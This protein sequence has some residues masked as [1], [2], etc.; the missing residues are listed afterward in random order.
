M[1]RRIAHI[2][3]LFLILVLAQV[4]IF[5]H[6]LLFGVAA[7]IVFIYV[8]TRMP[9]DCG[10]NTIITIGFLMG[11]LVDICAD[12][13]GMNTLACTILAAVRKPVLL[14][15]V[16]HDDNLSEIIPS[17][18]TLGIW[19]Y[20][21]Y[22]LTMVLIYCLIYFSIEFFSLANIGDILLMA[23][24]STLLS[25]PLLLGIDSLMKKNRE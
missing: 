1:A 7:P 25:F 4:L 19:N 10:F 3:I 23:T 11:L 18:F 24:A 14:S 5:N 6:I 13:L 22:M 20:S 9:T 2:A 21:K 15:Y 12:T 8:I 17:T 16:Q